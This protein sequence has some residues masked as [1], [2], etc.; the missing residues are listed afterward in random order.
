MGRKSNLELYCELVFGV[1]ILFCIIRDCEVF[2]HASQSRFY[3][4][5]S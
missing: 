4:L 2:Y 3:V 1:S 5:E